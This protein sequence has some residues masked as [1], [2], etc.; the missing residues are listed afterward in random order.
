MKY[1]VKYIYFVGVGGFGMSG[2]VEVLV[3]FGYMVSGFDLVVSV[4]ICCFEGEGVRVMIGYVV[5]NIKGV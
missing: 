2:I 1:K 4:I 5:E 3:Y